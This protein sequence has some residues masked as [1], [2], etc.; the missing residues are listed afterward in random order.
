MLDRRALR[1]A[2]AVTAPWTRALDRG[3]RAVDAGECDRCG[4]HPRLL[5]TCGPAHWTALCRDCALEVGED[6]WCDG[7]ADDGAD[8]RDWAAQLPTTWPTL[9]RLW[10]VATGEVAVD[11]AWIAAARADVADEVAALLPG[12]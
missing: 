11:D 12:D 4:R 1:A 7:H 3:P 9:V 2:L 8:L 10:W 5:P 6:G